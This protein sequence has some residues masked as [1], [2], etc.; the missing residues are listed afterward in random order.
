MRQELKES[1]SLASFNALLSGRALL[2]GLDYFRFIEYVIL[3]QQFKYLKTG[4]RKILDVGCGEEPLGLF[5]SFKKGYSVYAIDSDPHKISIQSKYLKKLQQKRSLM[6]SPAVKDAGQTG[7]ADSFFD[8]IFCLALLL[9]LPGDKDKEIMKEIGRIVK[10]GGY[11]FVSLSIGGRYEEVVNDS[12]AKGFTRV[13]DEKAIDTRILA[14]SGLTLVNKI[15][16]GEQRFSFSRKWYRLPFC[17]RLP[18]RWLTP[19]L[20]LLFLQFGKTLSHPNGIFLILTKNDK[21]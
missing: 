15:Y 2:K 7:F 12:I 11:V 9:L 18:F 21:E 14:P 8:S 13:Y 6:Y 1:L 5:M 19:L 4:N 17:L 10:P 20:S 3:F 16:F